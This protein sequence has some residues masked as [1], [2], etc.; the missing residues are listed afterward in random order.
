MDGMRK[1][2]LSRNK[3]AKLIEYFV[4]GATSRRAASLIGV[5]KKTAAYYF[6][7]LRE[8]ITLQT[9]DESNEAFG[10]EIELDESC[11]GEQRKGKR[12]R[13][14]G[15]EA[16]VFGLLRRGGKVYAKIIT[17]M[18]SATL[19]PTMG[20]KVTPD[21]IVYTNCQNG[22]NTLDVSKFRYYRINYPPLF[23]GQ[24]NYIDGVENFW[25]QAK[26]HLHRYNGIPRDNFPLYLKECEWRFNNPSLQSRLKMLKQWVREHMG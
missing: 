26:R 5:D 23:A 24:K 16:P 25:S 17:N 10:G 7:R 11:F 9:N 15:G 2:R 14:A 1:S 3:Q 18:A 13:E 21:S 6:Q 22:N 19:T 12:G 8:I 4:A 20:N